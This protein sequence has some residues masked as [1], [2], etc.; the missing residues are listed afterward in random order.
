MIATERIYLYT[1]AT[2]LSSE[3]RR[4]IVGYTPLAL[5]MLYYD[6]ALINL[7]AA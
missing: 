5:R 3:V 4:Q 7:Y 6:Y 1:R 2:S